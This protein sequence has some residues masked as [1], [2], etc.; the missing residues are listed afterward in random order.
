MEALAHFIVNLACR[1]CFHAFKNEVS[2]FWK[3]WI[4]SRDN[5]KHDIDW[6]FTFNYLL[7]GIYNGV[8]MI[9]S[10]HTLKKRNQF[11][12]NKP[13]L[14]AGRRLWAP[15]LT[16]SAVVVGGVL[17]RSDSLS[18]LK[19][20]ILGILSLGSHQGIVFYRLDWIHMENQHWTVLCAMVTFVCIEYLQWLAS[21][22]KGRDNLL[23]IPRYIRW[24]SYYLAI[25]LIAFN[26]RDSAGF[27]YAQF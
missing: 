22:P 4:I 14:M 10:T 19:N 16:F 26:L 21:S 27:L 20:Y 7:F 12:K 5:D 6:S 18:S 13:A 17:F 1:L 15:T 2:K 25:I 11:F 8:L 3:F 23:K 9:F 24:G